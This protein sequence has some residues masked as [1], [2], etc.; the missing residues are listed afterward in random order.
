MRTMVKEKEE[1][2][3]EARLEREEVEPRGASSTGSEAHQLW[4]RHR[5]PVAH[6]RKL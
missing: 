1:V 5:P 4:R 3:E 6:W 2:W